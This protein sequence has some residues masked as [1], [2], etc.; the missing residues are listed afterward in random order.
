M[1][2][3]II[4]FFTTVLFLFTACDNKNKDMEKLRAENPNAHVVE[5]VGHTNASSY[6]YI[7][8][9]EKDKEYWIA[10]PQMKVNEGDILFLVKVWK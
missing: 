8:V 1:N 4:V 5:V 2:K 10:V 9:E 7:K 6:T 3:I